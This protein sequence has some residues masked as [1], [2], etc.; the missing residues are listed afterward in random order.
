VG[1]RAQFVVERATEI[2]GSGHVSR[3]RLRVVCRSQGDAS[4]LTG[5]TNNLTVSASR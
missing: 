5:G 1:V 3:V 2:A 4:P